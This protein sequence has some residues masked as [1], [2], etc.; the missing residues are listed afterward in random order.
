MVAII[1]I[2]GSNAYFFAF[3]AFFRRRFRD[4]VDVDVDLF[5]FSRARFFDML[6]LIF[7]QS[8]VEKNVFFVDDDDVKFSKNFFF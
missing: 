7:L 1:A 6:N 3:V 8:A 5:F 2:V 4:D